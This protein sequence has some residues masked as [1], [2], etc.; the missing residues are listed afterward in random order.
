MADVHVEGAGEQIDQAVYDEQI[1]AGKSERMARAKAKAAWVRAQKKAKLAEQEAGDEPAADAGA[2]TDEPPKKA[3]AD[4]H[5]EGA[6]EQIDQA[7]YD[8]QIAAGKSERMARAKAKAAWVRAQKQKQLDDEDAGESEAGDD[9]SD[10]GADA[11]AEG[12]DA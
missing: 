9:A 3:L 11:S 12:G 6:G 4:V 8:E 2:S 10:A 1:A 5:V 7:V